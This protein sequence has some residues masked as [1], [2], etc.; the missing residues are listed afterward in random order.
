MAYGNTALIVLRPH[1]ESSRP[2]PRRCWRSLG[3]LSRAL[4]ARLNNNTHDMCLGISLL[5]RGSMLKDCATACSACA[6][7]TRL[8][9]FYPKKRLAVIGQGLEVAMSKLSPLIITTKQDHC[10]HQYDLINNCSIGFSESIHHG[11]T[12]SARTVHE[13]FRNHARFPRW[14]LITYATQMLH[15][16][17]QWTSSA[18]NTCCKAVSISGLHIR[19]QN[20]K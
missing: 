11:V 3:P 18:Q 10:G 20:V 14:L 16:M 5:S 12:L 17:G 9:W 6:M 4:G 1:S 8:S 7:S 19:G 13:H 2:T 15:G